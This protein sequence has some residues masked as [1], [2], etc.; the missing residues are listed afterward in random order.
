M[1]NGD[2]RDLGERGRQA[3]VNGRPSG[4]PMTFIAADSVSAAGMRRRRTSLGVNGTMPRRVADDSARAS[5]GS[6]H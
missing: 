1:V 5:Q 4:S 6:L 2:S 3:S